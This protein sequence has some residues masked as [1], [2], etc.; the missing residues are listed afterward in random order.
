MKLYFFLLI[1]YG[2]LV[3]ACAPPGPIAPPRQ[4]DRES[5]AGVVRQAIMQWQNSRSF[6]VTEGVQKIIV[7]EYLA[8]TQEC[9]P[10]VHTPQ[11]SLEFYIFQ[12]LD[13]ARQEGMDYSPEI[14]CHPFAQ[15]LRRK[16]NQYGQLR[17]ISEPRNSIAIDNQVLDK[18]FE[19]FLLTAGEHQVSI[20]LTSGTTCK[21]VLS[22]HRGRTT[23]FPCKLGGN[24]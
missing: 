1:C 14:I 9:G 12:Y 22:I 2:V 8:S 3:T 5:L 16:A 20:Q 11:R 17:I 7:D 23:Q 10:A 13:Y 24:I 4:D 19:H 6:G 18:Q 21:N 15:S